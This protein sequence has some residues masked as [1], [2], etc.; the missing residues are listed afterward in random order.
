MLANS[1]IG[2]GRRQTAEAKGGRLR[3]VRLIRFRAVPTDRTAYGQLKVP[4]PV[5][6]NRIS[7]PIY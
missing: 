2:A 3:R 6:W 1:F 7:L 4:F 5:E